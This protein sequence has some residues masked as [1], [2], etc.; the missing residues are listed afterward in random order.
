MTALAG[1]SPMLIL[2]PFFFAACG[3]MKN[4]HDRE[5]TRVKCSGASDWP[6]CWQQAQQLCPNGY[7]LANQEADRSGL[8]REV[9]IAC[10]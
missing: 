9:D 6:V 1:L 5:W 8:K 7:D 2:L 3:S 10:K 4:V